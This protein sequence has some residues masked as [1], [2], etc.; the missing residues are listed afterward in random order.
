MKKIRVALVPRVSG[1]GGMVSF[2]RKLSAGM[3]ERGIEIS[4]DVFDPGVDRI[5]VI[6][7]TRQ[8]GQWWQ[9]RRR[10]VRIVQRLDG[11]N[12]LHRVRKTGFRHYLRAEYGNLILRLIR[13]RLAHRVVYQSI[14]A[15]KWWENAGGKAGI[16][17]SVVY[18]GVDLE[19]FRP[20][21]QGG[22]PTDRM[23]VLMVEGKI[24]GGYELGLEH[25]LSMALGLSDQLN[26]AHSRIGETGVELV[27]VGK[28][29]DKTKAGIDRKLARSASD[30]QVSL[31]WAGL[32]PSEQVAEFD[33]SAHLL[34]SADINAA[35]PNSV[36]EG[37][38]SG[39]PVVA[40]E[41]GALPE[42]LA[43]GAGKV[44]PYGGDPWK[45]DPPNTRSLAEAAFEILVNREVY[46]R[47]A[48]ARAE[49][50]FGLDRMVDGYL[51]A[52]LG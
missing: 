34:Y 50:L 25:A 43:G 31:K 23:R 13:N 44:V 37:M 11:M 27:V 10:G 20:D 26:H 32:V 40:F 4:Y 45:L 9:A 12:W 17:S 47:A 51:E 48:R 36:L 49:N 52:M 22:L 5:L 33:R 14:F 46:S 8:L 6:G 39:T 28:V 3:A 7:G 19:V 24:M 30:K 18:N 21:E 42:L 29:I 2:R 38:A 35:C 1:V 41:T 16:P 15:R